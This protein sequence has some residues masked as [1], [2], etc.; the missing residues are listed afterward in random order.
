MWSSCPITKIFDEEPFWRDVD[1]RGR[2][3]LN[4]GLFT[5]DAIERLQNPSRDNGDTPPMGRPHER[6]R[7]PTPR[8]L[9]PCPLF[10]RRRHH[11]QTQTLHTLPDWKTNVHRRRLCQEFTPHLRWKYFTQVSNF[12]PRRTAPR[13]GRRAWNH[14]NSTP[15][16][17][18]FHPAS[19][20]KNVFQQF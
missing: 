16:Q 12:S 2:C 1:P 10:I 3:T 15:P 6:D 14:L 17:N 18:D 13:L 11:Y 8:D 4:Q 5:G 9:Q 20:K 7:L 19:L